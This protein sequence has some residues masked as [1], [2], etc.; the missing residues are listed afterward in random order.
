[1]EKGRSVLA[2]NAD[3]ARHILRLFSEILS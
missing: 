1:M 2:L 3:E